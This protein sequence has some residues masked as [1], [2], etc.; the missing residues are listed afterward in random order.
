MRKECFKT[1]LFC[2]RCNEET[3]HNVEYQNKL[4]VRVTCEVCEKTIG[5]SWVIT[6]NPLPKNLT[7]T[8]TLS[9]CAAVNHIATPSPSKE[10]HTSP[11]DPSLLFYGN[12]ILSR[13]LSKPSRLNQEM[14]RDLTLF[15]CSIPVRFMT[16]PGR[17]AKEFSSLKNNSQ[18]N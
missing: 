1:E 7:H 13:I 15:F 2:L 6:T 14:H 3:I 18:H 9:S 4:I 17:M 8:A 10:V 16:K 11:H 5:P 12:L